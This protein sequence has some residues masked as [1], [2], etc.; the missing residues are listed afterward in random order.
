MSREI[1]L[2]L[3]S[4]TPGRSL[5]RRRGLLRLVSLG[6]AARIVTDMAIVN[7]CYL[8]ALV[9][10]LLLESGEMTASAG[11]QISAALDIYLSHCWLLTMTAAVAYSVSGLYSHGALDRGRL[12]AVAILQAVSLTYLAF[13]F[14][15]YVGLAKDWLAPTPRVAMALSWAMT[16]AAAGGARLWSR[17]WRVVV[18]LE[19]SPRPESNRKGPIRRVL[20]IGGA[21]YIGSVLCRQLLAAGYSVRVL[22]A[23][24]YGEG[25]VA[26]LLADPRFELIRGDS[27]DIGAVISSMLGIDAVIHLGELVGDPACAVDEALTLEINLAATRMLAEAARG[28]GVKRF[29]YAS[30]CSVYGAS[31]ALLDERSELNPVSLYARAKIGSERALLEL[32]GEKFHPVILRFATVFGHSYRPRF[33][34]VVNVLTAK[35]VQDGEITV[36]NGDQWRPFVHVSDVCRAMIRCLQAPVQTVKGQVFNVGD[37]GQNFTIQQVGELVRD[38]VPGSRL[39]ESGADGDRR[40][41]R[42]HFSKIR[43]QLGFTCQTGLREGVEQLLQAIRQG[44]VGDYRAAIYSNHKTLVSRGG[45]THLKN[46]SIPALYFPRRLPVPP[47]SERPPQGTALEAPGVASVQR[48]L[49]AAA[50]PRAGGRTN[51]P[52]SP[53]CRKRHMSLHRRPRVPVQGR[54]N[55]WR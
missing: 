38:L 48:S 11:V 7:G 32:D 6:S 26:Q 21:G 10:R 45:Q 24:L 9:L 12:K 4:T 31:D 55:P 1:A 17:L 40:N 14:I 29:I 19:R 34:L 3:C 27:R 51:G 30:S 23:L 35:A 47:R 15:Q 46:R 20:V 42:V 44:Q 33:D 2:Q 28:Y 36:F 5:I 16:L 49:L 43:R 18:E 54:S 52:V 25:P 41:Y 22:D 53:S 13:G 39:I 8:A 50:P 37:D